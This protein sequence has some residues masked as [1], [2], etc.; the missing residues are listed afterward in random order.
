MVR[1]LG[2]PGCCSGLSAVRCRLLCRSIVT[3]DFLRVKGS[4]GTIFAM[5]D[6]AT[7][8]QPRALA[9]AQVPFTQLQPKQHLVAPFFVTLHASLPGVQ[10]SYRKDTMCGFLQEL[11]HSADV[12]KDGML[13]LG[14]LRCLMRDAAKEY[15]HLQEHARFLDR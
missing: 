13:D 12:N 10:R 7:I 8:D 5:G 3:D 14:E 6:A 1:W 11:F 4:S 2:C 9:R 15:S